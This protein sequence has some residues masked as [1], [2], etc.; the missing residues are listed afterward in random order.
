[1]VRAG[2]RNVIAI[3][4]GRV[5]RAIRPNHAGKA[6]HGAVIIA[7]QTFVGADLDWRRPARAA[8]AGARKQNDSFDQA[9]FRPTNIDVA[10]IWTV[11]RVG[12]DVKLIFKRTARTTGM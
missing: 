4:P 12:K 8:I 11:S 1:I 7:G 6:F 9:E 10:R 3:G 5:D 2:E